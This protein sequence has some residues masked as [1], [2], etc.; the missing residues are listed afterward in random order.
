MAYLRFGGL[1]YEVPRASLGSVKEAIDEGLRD[2]RLVKVELPDRGGGLSTL[3]ITP[4]APVVL[5]E[6]SQEED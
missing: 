5:E 1:A 2:G 4:G 6:Y 3:Y